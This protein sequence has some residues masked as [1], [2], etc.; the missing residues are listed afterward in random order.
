MGEAGMVL[1]DPGGRAWQGS[2]PARGSYPVGSGDAF[3]AGMLVGLD[4]GASWPDAARLALG[5]AAANAEVPGAARLE[6][7]R[8][9][10]LAA[11]SAVATL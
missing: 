8:A 4:A 2:T 6:A 10:E 11:G 9:R 7:G 5:A 3:L 1:V